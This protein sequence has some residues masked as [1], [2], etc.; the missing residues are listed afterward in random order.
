MTHS[1][2][3]YLITFDKYLILV[4][5]ERENIFFHIS[6]DETKSNMALI[7]ILYQGLIMCYRQSILLF[8]LMGSL[9]CEARRHGFES[10]SLNYIAD[11][12]TECPRI[13]R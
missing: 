13:Q 10:Y 3:Q 9:D 8:C 7:C 11:V 12:Y 4:K 5:R 1:R 6:F 2:N